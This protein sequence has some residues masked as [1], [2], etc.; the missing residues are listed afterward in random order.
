[1][2]SDE[3]DNA[4]K[5]AQSHL[6]AGVAQTGCRFTPAAKGTATGE[7]GRGG[8]ELGEGHVGVQTEHP[9]SRRL[10]GPHG[11]AGAGAPGLVRE[12]AS[13]TLLPLPSGLW[14]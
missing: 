8:P 7:T 14:G 2:I 13:A 5:R 10:A 3:G 6:P 11:K 12:G 9:K 4:E 1:M